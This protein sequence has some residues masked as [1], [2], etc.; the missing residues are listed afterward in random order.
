MSLCRRFIAADLLAE[1][2]QGLVLT[3]EPELNLRGSSAAV[4]VDEDE[5]TDAAGSAK[6]VTTSKYVF[7]SCRCEDGRRHRIT[8]RVAR[9]SWRLGA[10]RCAVCQ[11]PFSES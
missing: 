11:A 2:E 3:R 5:D 6:A 8:I 1:L 7:A 10:I 9:G 4:S